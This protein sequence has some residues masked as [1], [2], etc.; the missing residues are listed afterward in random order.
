M[1]WYSEVHSSFIYLVDGG[2]QYVCT[3]TVTYTAP[4]TAAAATV[5]CDQ[6]SSAVTTVGSIIAWLSKVPGAGLDRK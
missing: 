6:Y 2:L 5:S 4:D 3:G 1:H